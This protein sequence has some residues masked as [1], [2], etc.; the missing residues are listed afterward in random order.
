MFVTASVVANSTG[1]VN[2]AVTVLVALT[3]AARNSRSSTV[4]HVAPD[5]VQST[6]VVGEDAVGNGVLI[7]PAFTV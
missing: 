1:L 7:E 2:A 6:G 4:S 3:V 5:F